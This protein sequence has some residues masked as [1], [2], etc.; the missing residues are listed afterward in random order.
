MSVGLNS[1]ITDF[2]RP[3]LNLTIVLDVSGSMD[4]S[5]D[6]YYYDKNGNKIK[7]EDRKSK[8]QLANEAVVSI[9][10]HLKPTD[11][12]AVVLFSSASCIDI[13]LT[14]FKEFNL[15][16]LHKKLLTKADSGGTNMSAGLKTGIDIYSPHHL[17]EPNYQNRMIFL[18]DAITGD[19]KMRTLLLSLSAVALLHAADI[20]A[21]FDV[22]AAKEASLKLSSTGIIEKVYV[23]VG[24]RVQK[25]D[26]LLTLDSELQQAEIAQT[27][28]DLELMKMASKYAQK[29][30]KRTTKLKG[31]I[32]EA[33]SDATEQL[34]ESSALQVQL[35]EAKLQLKE[36]A[37]SKASLK[38]PFSGT[39]TAKNV[40]VGDGYG[41]VAGMAALVLQSESAVKLIVNF[42]EKYWKEVAAGDSFHFK[43]DG[44]TKDRVGLISK[45]YPTINAKNRMMSAEV[46]TKDIPVGLF[47]DGKIITK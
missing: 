43:V 30:H 34:A 46:L 13:P 14:T 41:G 19:S 12:F 33:K 39:I 47:G 7:S 42:D 21:T 27:K 44:D 22:V 32:D 23:D 36:I 29:S 11:K 5:F 10:K 25:G 17:S 4:G 37:L 26:L 15:D 38:A 40:E 6:D 20:Y 1:G 35:I 24:S 16:D 18:T 3:P 8:M 31:L 45:I 9:T 28:I 2:K